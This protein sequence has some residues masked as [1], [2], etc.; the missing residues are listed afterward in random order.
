MAKTCQFSPIDMIII[1]NY[2]V[3]IIKLEKLNIMSLVD[4]EKFANFLVQVPEL[5]LKLGY[6][7]ALE[8]PSYDRTAA[9]A[10]AAVKEGEA[11]GLDF[12]QEEC[13][14][15]LE[16]RANSFSSDELSDMQLDAVAGG[17]ATT[18]MPTLPGRK[19]R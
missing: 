12:T 4:V 9:F 6:K 7:E 13:R 1:A 5:L 8:N 17:A 10:A 18:R 19:P 11:L 3:L 2:C 16:E 14:N 15:W